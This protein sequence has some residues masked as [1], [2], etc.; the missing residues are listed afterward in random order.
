MVA[1]YTVSG[2]Q[3]IECLNGEYVKHSDFAQLGK[4]YGKLRYVLDKIN[5]NRRNKTNKEV[6]K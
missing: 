1:R 2:G 4:S 6:S 5:K 3:M